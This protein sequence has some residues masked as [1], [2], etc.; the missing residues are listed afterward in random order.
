MTIARRRLVPVLLA[1]MLVGLLPS[2]T[3]A[4]SPIAGDDPSEACI[5]DVTGGSFPIPEDWGQFVFPPG[6]G[7][8]CWIGDNDSDPD[9]DSLTWSIVTPPAHGDLIL[10]GPTGLTLYT[11]DPEYS[12]LPGD[13][14]GGTWVSDSFVYGVSDG[15]DFDTATF[16]FWLAPFNDPPTFNPGGDV[17]VDED[18]GPFSA[19]WATAVTPGPAPSE[20]DQ[21]VTFQIVVSEPDLFA[22]PP[23]IGPDGTLTFT[24]ALDQYGVAQVTVRAHDDGGLES[25]YGVDPPDPPDDTS[26]PVMFQ[27]AVGSVNDAPIAVADS[28]TVPVGPAIAIP[29][30][31]NDT[32]ADDD[33]LQITDASGATKG[34]VAITGGGTALTYDPDDD[35]LGIDAFTYTVADG[36]GGTDSAAVTVTLGDVTPP[37]IT[38]ITEGLPGQ[39]VGTST[40]RA[41]IK[42][43][44]QDEGSGVNNYHLQVSVNDGAFATV[45]LSNPTATWVDRALTTGATYRFRVRAKDRQGNTSAFTAWPAITPTRLQE[46]TSLAS[47]TGTWSTALHRAALN[48]RTRYAWSSS[49]K[50]AVRFIGR[51]VGWVATRMSG[52]GRADVRIDGVLVGTVQ[53]DRSATAFRQLVV[54]QHLDAFGWHTIEIRPRGDGRVDLDALVILR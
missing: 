38:S 29:V 3:W 10:D 43:A 28:A 21:T 9:G 45:V 35:A 12:T 52:S 6:P 1:A 47:Y 13:Q 8:H 2:T 30:L 5:N 7:Y 40:V 19:A 27:I 31:G 51:D 41:R 48:G 37:T 25:Y 18:S 42:W 39:T 20:A 32:D 4:A 17:T 26:D 14:P 15:T 44:G 24:P 11:P 50:V 23:A 16:R 49:R 36:H 22:V 46:A 53:L 34:V 54:G 33:P